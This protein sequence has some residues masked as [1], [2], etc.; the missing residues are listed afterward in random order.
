MKILFNLIVWPIAIVFSIVGT[1]FA[2]VIGA[3]IALVATPP[4]FLRRL[5]K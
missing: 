5:V 1:I 2:L 3:V 4:D